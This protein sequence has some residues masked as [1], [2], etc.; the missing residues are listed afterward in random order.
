MDWGSFGYVGSDGR[1]HRLS[2]FVMVLGRS[3]AIYGEFARRADVASFMQCHV[4]AFEYFGGVPRR[5]LY[6]NAKVVV[7]GRDADGH[8]E[9]GLGWC[10]SVAN[11]YAHGRAGRRPTRC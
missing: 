2:A 4:N 8:P 5:C 11:R 1:K 6:D 7:L 3:R 10:D 9:Q